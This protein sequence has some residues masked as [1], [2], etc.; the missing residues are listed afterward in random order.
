MF[1]SYKPISLVI[2]LKNHGSVNN[3]LCCAPEMYRKIQD[4]HFT[5]PFLSAIIYALN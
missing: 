4:Y 2:L 5:E 1:Y 3:K